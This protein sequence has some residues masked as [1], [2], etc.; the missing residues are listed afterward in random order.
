MQNFGILTPQVE[1]PE[2][3]PFG[4]FGATLLGTI[5]FLGTQIVAQGQHRWYPPAD[6]QILGIDSACGVAPVGG[7]IAVDVRRNAFEPDATTIFL[8]IPK[9]RILD[10]NYHGDRKVPVVGLDTMSFADLDYLRFDR[11]AVGS[12]VPGKN[13]TLQVWGRWKS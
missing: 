2:T 8:G 9:P 3:A 10:G 12:S 11:I 1:M 7:D 4:A 6:C 13:L 5:T